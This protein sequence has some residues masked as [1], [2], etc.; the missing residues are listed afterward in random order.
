[1]AKTLLLAW[2]SPASAEVEAEL[3]QWYEGSH[4]PELRAAIPSITVAH[5][6]KLHPA[7]DADPAPTRYLTVYELDEDDVDAA[8]AALNAAIGSGRMTFTQTINMTEHPPVLEWYE[9]L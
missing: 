1:M 4:I 3:N 6:Y 9:H 2:S 7:P 5:R 8:A